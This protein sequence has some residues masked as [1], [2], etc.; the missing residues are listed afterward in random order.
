[1]SSI[2]EGEARQDKAIA[3]EVTAL[4][5]ASPTADDAREP[6]AAAPDAEPPASQEGVWP[7]LS[8]A[9]LDRG[10]QQAVNDGPRMMGRQVAFAL[11]ASLRH[12]PDSSLSAPLPPPA[13]T[14]TP[15]EAG[16]LALAALAEHLTIQRRIELLGEAQDLDDPA[17][18]ARILLL[19]A[20]SLSGEKRRSTIRE[21]Y[22]AA[23]SVAH[24]GERVHL[25][26]AMLPQLQTSTDGE[27]PSGLVAET[28]DLASVIGNTEARLRG[29]TALAPYLPPT[30]QAALLLAV[31]DTI[32]TMPGSDNQ[33][34]ALVALAPHLLGEVHH[35]TLTVAA[36]IKD[37]AP[38]ARA[39]TTLAQYLPSRLQPRLRAAALEAIAT[40]PGEDER[41][42]ALAAFAP[43]LEAVSEGE[44]T[45]PVLLERALALAVNMHRRDARAKALV[46]LQARL[47]H[48]LKGEALAAVNA[49]PDEHAR[50]QMLADLTPSLPQDLAVAALAIAH[51]IRQ[52]DARFLALKSLGARM[53]GKAAERT[54]LDA[55]AVAVALPRQL[56]R[57][58]ALSE[59]APRLPTEE[60]RYRTLVNALTTA[61]SIP[62]ERARVRALS[63]LAPLLAD[64]AQLLA[65]ALADAYTITNPVEKISALIALIPYL[66]QE[67]RDRTI[68][69]A[70][71]GMPEITVEY[72]RSRAL[73]SLVP[74][75]A[76][77]QLQRAVAIALAIADPYDRSTTLLALLPRLPAD[78]QPQVLSHT[79]EAA[80][81]IIDPYDRA[82]ALAA[83]WPHAPPDF[84]AEIVRA[85]LDAVQEIED[86]YDRASG[87][88]LF[89]PLLAAENMPAALPPASQVLREALLAAC[90]L[91]DSTA[92][93]DAFHH[94]STYWIGVHPSPVAYA[95]WCE[96][97]PALS[98]RPVPQLLSDIA[99]LTPLLREI[100]GKTAALEA[101]QAV[102]VARQW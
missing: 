21:A 2:T 97:L 11:A 42:Q 46:G 39:L 80:R 50:A 22:Q 20:P 69:V 89:A 83:L 32:A 74:A 65:D 23:R 26:T 82:T 17:L 9:A 31:L 75:L 64:H 101:S 6:P 24:P 3:A 28:L 77:E 29:L 95:L 85:V 52:R 100:G 59:V 27:L 58:M 72:R 35:R 78:E 61:R 87:I 10:W 94:L 79:W 63:T 60:L 43:H 53:E 48:H 13:A 88:S 49:I 70:L 40:I 33:A 16:L 30:A 99:A 34:S 14:A 90:E 81:E 25:L 15:A 47:P 19:L 86:D 73:V 7:H 92:R 55:L 5:E 102:A 51:D 12:Q 4:G 93:A 57:V 84:Q 66:P 68:E 8:E 67:P 56:E 38:R 45:F 1:M 76:G 37:P 71:D 98:R 41:A 54:W 91:E 44:E 18:R 96:V 62:K 36:H